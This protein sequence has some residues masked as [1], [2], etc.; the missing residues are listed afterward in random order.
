M[1]IAGVAALVAIGGLVIVGT[2]VTGS[3]SGTVATA[4]VCQQTGKTTW[5][6][7]TAEVKYVR[8][9]WTTSGGESMSRAWPTVAAITYPGRVEITTPAARGSIDPS[10][11]GYVKAQVQ[12]GPSSTSLTTLPAVACT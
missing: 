11:D 10:I 9:T 7:P 2:Q 6:I 1:L 5:T 12:Y 4:A 3:R 8:I